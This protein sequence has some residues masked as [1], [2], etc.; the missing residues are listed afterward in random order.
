MHSVIVYTIMVGLTDGFAFSALSETVV[1]LDSAKPSLKS[2]GQRRPL[3]QRA[4]RHTRCEPGE[5]GQGI[6]IR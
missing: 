2:R 1:A 3:T 5:E 4:D 6:N